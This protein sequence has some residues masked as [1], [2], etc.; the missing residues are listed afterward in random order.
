MNWGGGGGE[1]ERQREKLSKT[2]QMIVFSPRRRPSHKSRQEQQVDYKYY[3][4]LRGM[5]V[6]SLAIG[7]DSPSLGSIEG[8]KEE[9]ACLYSGRTHLGQKRLSHIRHWC[10][11]PGFP[12]PQ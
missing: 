1:K 12:L 8:S 6:T 3:S 4:S 9:H 10:Q 11:K 7:S 2:T 5:A